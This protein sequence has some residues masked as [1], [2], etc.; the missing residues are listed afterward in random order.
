MVGE[1]GT[2]DLPNLPFTGL[3]AFLRKIT[4]LLQGFKKFFFN[5][6]VISPTL[7]GGRSR[8]DGGGVREEEEATLSFPN[9]LFFFFKPPCHARFSQERTYREKR[10]K[11]ATHRFARKEKK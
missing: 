1:E 7:T 11:S 9:Q 10:S 6:S 3:K 5:F 2:W 4:I 8:G